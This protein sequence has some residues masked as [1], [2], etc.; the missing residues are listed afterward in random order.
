MSEKRSRPTDTGSDASE[1]VE[2][3]LKGLDLAE[4]GAQATETAQ[5]LDYIL[6]TPCRSSIR[7]STLENNTGE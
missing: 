2:R 4:K 3:D 1:G 5:Q 6:S 7:A